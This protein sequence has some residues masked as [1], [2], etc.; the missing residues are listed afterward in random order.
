MYT[1]PLFT[2]TSHY[3][4]LL[5]REAYSPLPSYIQKTLLK[6]TT[7]KTFPIYTNNMH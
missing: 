5:L 2:T 3:T 4:A 1:E 7:F 6:L